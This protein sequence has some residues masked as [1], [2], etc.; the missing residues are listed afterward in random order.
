MDIHKYWIKSLFAFHRNETKLT[1]TTDTFD[2]LYTKNVIVRDIL[3]LEAINIDMDHSWKSKIGRHNTAI[4]FGMLAH[5]IPA[6]SMF[7]LFTYRND[8]Y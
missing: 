8:V 6:I 1:Q 2:F 5:E 4:D 7:H 3:D